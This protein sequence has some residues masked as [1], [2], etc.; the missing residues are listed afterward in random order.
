VDVIQRLGPG[1][2]ARAAALRPILPIAN[3]GEA[4]RRGFAAILLARVWLAYTAL[5]DEPGTMSGAAS[6]ADG[7]VHT[8]EPNMITGGAGIVRHARL[9]GPELRLRLRHRERHRRIVP[10]RLRG[11]G[12][13]PTRKCDTEQWQRREG[14]REKNRPNEEQSSQS[15]YSQHR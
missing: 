1:I 9:A 12:G 8:W 10:A 15:S 7:A 6:G 2:R 5:R 11:R 13:R 14:Q 3:A 4:H